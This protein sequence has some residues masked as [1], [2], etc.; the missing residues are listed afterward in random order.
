[1][2]E[3]REGEEDSHRRFL[4]EEEDTGDGE[5]LLGWASTRWRTT[6]GRVRGRGTAC[7]G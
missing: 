5:C 4:L 3:C 1:M 7:A 2:E 6:L